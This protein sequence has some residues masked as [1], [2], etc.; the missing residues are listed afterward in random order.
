MKWITNTYDPKAPDAQFSCARM[1]DE[2]QAEAW[3][4]YQLWL[5]NKI[6]GE[7]KATKEYTAEQLKAMGMVG[8]YINA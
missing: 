3:Q 7:P 4:N 6:I 2:T 5:S 1:G 8:V